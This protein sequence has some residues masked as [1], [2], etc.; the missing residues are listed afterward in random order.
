MR[1]DMSLRWVVFG[2]VAP[3]MKTHLLTDEV[4]RFWWTIM[5]WIF[6]LTKQVDG[7]R[8]FMRMRRSPDNVLWSERRITPEKHLL[9]G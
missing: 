8:R 5:F 3:F 4:D 2:I 6:A 9:M 1:Y 7:D